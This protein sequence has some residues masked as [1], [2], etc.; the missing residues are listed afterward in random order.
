MPSVL[1]EIGNFNNPANAQT[2][3][4]DALQK[5]LADALVTAIL[6]FSSPQAAAN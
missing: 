5:R 2:L 4:D 1:L 6:R 3:A